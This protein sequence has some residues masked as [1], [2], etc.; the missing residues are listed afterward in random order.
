MDF[1]KKVFRKGQRFLIVLF[2]SVLMSMSLS[3]QVPVAIATGGL[4]VSARSIQLVDEPE[5]PHAAIGLLAGVGALPGI[6]LTLKP[7]SYINVRL[8]YHHFNLNFNDLEIDPTSFGYVEGPKLKVNGAIHLSTINI[9]VDFMPLHGD[10]LRLAAG[11]GLG[12]NNS[13]SGRFELVDPLKVNDLEL[14]PEGS[15]LCG[16]YIFY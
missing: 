1:G 4:P 9:A 16:G 8:G 12:L 13:I 3:A 5:Y 7:A 6:E 2:S 15:W 10:W 11:V 14:S